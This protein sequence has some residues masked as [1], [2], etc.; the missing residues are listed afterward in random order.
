MSIQ[1]V[2]TPHT[3]D[4]QVFSCQ[5]EQGKD[6][7]EFAVWM[8]LSQCRSTWP[9]REKDI[10]EDLSLDVPEDLSFD[11]CIEVRLKREEEVFHQTLVLLYIFVHF[12]HS[13]TSINEFY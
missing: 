10:P 3:S 6:L 13:C 4:E 11:V 12:S 2:K 5:K 9:A 8:T 7:E 1:V